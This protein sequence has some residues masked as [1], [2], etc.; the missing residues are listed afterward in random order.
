MDRIDIQIDVWRSDFDKVVHAGT[1][2]SSRELREGVLRARAFASWRHDH[3]DASADGG[4]TLSH[5]QVDHEA[6][7]FLKSMANAVHMS[8]RGIVRTLSIARTIA[9]M[10]ES[11]AVRQEHMAEALSLR[12][13]TEGK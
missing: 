5:F 4:D 11:E 8:E 2:I 1:G 7:A 10:Y 9:D 13:R 3:Q 6:E 12:L